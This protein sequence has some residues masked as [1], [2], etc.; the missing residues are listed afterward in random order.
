VRLTNGCLV[1]F[2]FYA[3]KARSFRLTDSLTVGMEA[4]RETNCGAAVVRQFVKAQV[5][6]VHTC[7]AA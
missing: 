1:H 2:G 4:F 6:G 7:D 3:A 5:S